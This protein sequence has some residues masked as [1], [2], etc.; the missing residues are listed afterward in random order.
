MKIFNVQLNSPSAFTKNSQNYLY[1]SRFGELSRA[2]NLNQIDRDT[3]S[4][5]SAKTRTNKDLGEVLK[6]PVIPKITTNFL[7]KIPNLPCVYCGEPMLALSVRNDIVASA[8]NATGENLI[9]ILTDNAKFF[10][11]NKSDIV[12]QI[13]A[14]AHKYP[15]YNIQELLLA[16]KPDY[17]ELLENEQKEIIRNIGAKFAQY[18][19][20]PQ[21]KKISSL[22]LYEAT[23]WVNDEIGTEPFKCQV[24]YKELKEIL[25]L[26]IF[27]NKRATEE[28]LEIASKMPQSKENQSAFIVKYSRREP[29]EIIEQLL[30]EPFVT[31]EHIK[32]QYNGGK[33]EMNNLVIACAD[34]N[35][36][37]RGCMPMYDFVD[38]HPEIE[39]NI[40][41]QFKYLKK[42]SRQ[43]GKYYMKDKSELD[44]YISDV[45]KTFM[46][47]SINKIH[48][49]E[50]II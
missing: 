43:P 6:V 4:F 24:F 26:P 23:Q 37:E 41:K 48:L 28:I 33:T 39:H 8:K 13:I 10:R 31:V 20:S 32:P 17:L 30:Y 40:K 9:K 2:V 47:E 27:R 35:G 7:R 11:K 21:A 50:Y 19:V 45:S 36:R 12:S 49:E 18:F 29:R 5:R 25:K 14:K 1:S 3:V 15:D 16:L 34:C 44:R 42:I 22:F 46:R 38:K